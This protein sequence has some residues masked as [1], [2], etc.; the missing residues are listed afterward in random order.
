MIMNAQA[1]LVPIVPQ[2]ELKRILYATDFSNASL[3]ALPLVSTLAR[4]YGSQ[5]FIAN[6]WAPVPFTLV[7]PENA[8]TLDQNEEEAARARMVALFATKELSGLPVSV[9]VEPGSPV[10]ELK[11]IVRRQNI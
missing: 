4:R 2:I 11:R 1:V 10:V 8:S 7:T 5:V 6:I 9:V 3:A